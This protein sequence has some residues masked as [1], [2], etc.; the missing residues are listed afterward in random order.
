[1]TAISRDGLPCALCGAG[2]T[3][4]L[5]PPT[6]WVFVG[7]DKHATLA[8]PVDLCHRCSSSVKAGQSSVSV[9]EGCLTY[10]PIDEDCRDH[11]RRSAPVRLLIDA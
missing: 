11:G 4:H 6:T 10:G 2:S 9:C 5:L 3:V 1:V 7:P 8:P